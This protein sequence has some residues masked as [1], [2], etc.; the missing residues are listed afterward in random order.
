MRGIML[1]KICDKRAVLYLLGMNIM[2]VG[3]L[4]STRTG[5]WCCGYKFCCLF[6]FN[7][8]AYFIRNGEFYIVYHFYNDSGNIVKVI[9]V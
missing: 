4:L 6:I 8:P 3:I 1:S 9:V 5:L 2:S 7:I